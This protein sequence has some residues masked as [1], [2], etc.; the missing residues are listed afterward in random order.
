MTRG[1][2]G[3][4][5][6]RFV[7]ALLALTS[8]LAADGGRCALAAPM[9]KAEEEQRLKVAMVFAD[10]AN[11]FI[12]HGRKTEVAR[13]TAEIKEVY[14]AAPNLAD[15]E[16]AVAEGTGA[17][18]EATPETDAHWKKVLGDAAKGW[19]KIGDLRGTAKDEAG[20]ASAIAKACEL[21]PTKPRLAKGLAAVKA[22]SGNKTKPEAA[23]LLL[24]RLRDADPDDSKAKYDALEAEMASSDVALVKAPGH[25]MVAWLSLPKGW[26]KKGEWDVL[27]T[28]EGAG[29][30]FLGATRGAAGSRGSRKFL[31]LGPCSLSNTNAL[32]PAK[33]PFYPPAVLEEWGQRRID[34]DLPGLEAILDMLVERYGASKKVAITGFSGGGNLCYSL[35]LRRPQRVWAAAPACANFQPGLVGDAT[36]VEDGGPPVHLFTGANDEHKDHVFGQ[37]PGIEG[38]T[39]WAMEAF[40]NL[41]FKNVKRTMLPG[42]G[43]SSCT[44]QVWTFLDEVLASRK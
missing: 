41:G 39:D 20:Q 36:P 32:E 30:N 42:V 31:V 44:T 38:Q 23:G 22:L 5:R 18:K 19:E 3:R 25:P 27:V 43:H 33:Y 35:L 11:W 1:S 29:S 16:K 21:D 34:F 12:D 10:A 4:P 2:R 15:L 14:P 26:T 37:K 28:V 7:W 6:L 40:G 13:C 24:G 17:E 8:L 9:G